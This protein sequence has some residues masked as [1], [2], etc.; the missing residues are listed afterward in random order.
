MREIK[1]RAWDN[2]AGAMRDWEYL[3]GFPTQGRSAPTLPRSALWAVEI[4]YWMRSR[5]HLLATVISG[6]DLK[7]KSLPQCGSSETSQPGYASLRQ[8]EPRRT[9]AATA[10]L[11]FHQREGFS[12]LGC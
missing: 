2:E 6:F 3:Q 8:S 1:F 11:R 12:K 7:Q 10:L 9:T 5:K 4:R